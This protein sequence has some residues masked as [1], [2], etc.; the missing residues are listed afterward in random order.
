[1]LLNILKKEKSK[2]KKAVTGKRLGKYRVIEKDYKRCAKIAQSEGCIN[3]PQLLP[4][5]FKANKKISRALEKHI[6]DVSAEALAGIGCTYCTFP[7]AT[8]KYAF[9]KIPEVRAKQI[10]QNIAQEIVLRQTSKVDH[11]QDDE[12]REEIPSTSEGKGEGDSEF[13]EVLEKGLRPNPKTNILKMWL[14]RIYQDVAHAHNQ[15]FPKDLLL[16]AENVSCVY[17]PFYDLPNQ[18]IAGC[19]C[20]TKVAEKAQ[21]DGE[22]VRRDIAALVNSIIEMMRIVQKKQSIQMILPIRHQTIADPVAAS[23]YKLIIKKLHKLVARRLIVEVASIPENGFNENQKEF[24]AFLSKNLWAVFIRSDLMLPIAIDVGSETKVMACGADI[25]NTPLEGE[26]F[27]QQLKTFSTR[28]LYDGK[29]SYI[30]GVTTKFQADAA[31]AAGVNYM[32]GPIIHLESKIGVAAHS[33]TLE[34]L[35][36]AV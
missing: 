35:Y 23:L 15:V 13:R 7:D 29:S 2:N 24:L 6:E 28:Y 11:A 17:K 5:L 14:E 1:M 12:A 31:A 33:T 20:Q 32:A 27:M 9:E 22:Y 16:L 4:D 21:N 34:E 8:V 19:I 25:S 36:V 3:L 10:A 18:M 26:M 30:M